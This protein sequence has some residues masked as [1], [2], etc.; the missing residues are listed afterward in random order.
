M[1]TSSSFFIC[2]NFF[3]LNFYNFKFLCLLLSVFLWKCFL[4]FNRKIIASIFYFFIFFELKYPIFIFLYTK[5]VGKILSKKQQRN[6]TKK[7]VNAIKI[8][9]KRKK[10]ENRKRHYAHKQYRNLFIE[11]EPS[12]Q[13]ENKKRQYTCDL[14]KTLF[15]NIWIKKIY[16]FCINVIDLIFS[17]SSKKLKLSFLGSQHLSITFFQA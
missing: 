11:N 1:F 15:R 16:F 9:L 8:Y 6:T 12:E 3:K 5:N 14:Y 2:F 7:V 13:K 10:I 17:G 4:P